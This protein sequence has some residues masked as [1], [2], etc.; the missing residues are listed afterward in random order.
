M[1]NFSDI[2]VEVT[3]IYTPSI[4]KYKGFWIDVMHFSTMNLVKKEYKN[5]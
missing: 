4:P 5:F 2:S 1:V 3:K